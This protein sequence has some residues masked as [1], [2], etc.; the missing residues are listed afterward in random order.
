MAGRDSPISSDASS[1]DENE[2]TTVEPL[3]AAVPAP[4]RPSRAPRP[5]RAPPPPLPRAPA[6]SEPTLV[7]ELEPPLDTAVHRM[8]EPSV[9][10]TAVTPLAPP[11]RAQEPDLDGQDAEDEELTG[12]VPGRAAQLI[13]VPELPPRAVAPSESDARRSRTSATDDDLP[14][15]IPYEPFGIPGLGDDGA[16]RRWLTRFAL[17]LSV[18]VVVLLVRLV[19]GGSSRHGNEPAAA[20]SAETAGSGPRTVRSASDLPVGFDRPP[21]PSPAATSAASAAPPR[22]AP[23]APEDDPLGEPPSRFSG[24]ASSPP[25]NARPPRPRR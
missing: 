22:T 14:V 25:K 5:P 12:T 11:A 1:P 4:P 20:A 18:V 13:A 17:V 19:A 10:D 3:P 8:P 15:P 16:P 9:A 2:N 23:A 24:G 7:G 6:L 21:E